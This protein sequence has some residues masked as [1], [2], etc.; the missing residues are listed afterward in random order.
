M[1]MM[2]GEFTGKPFLPMSFVSSATE[3]R[4]TAVRP[5]LPVIPYL[6]LPDIFLACLI[7]VR[8]LWQL[9]IIAFALYSYIILSGLSYTTGDGLNDYS[10]G[11]ALSTRLVTACHFLFLTNPLLDFRHESDIVPAT[12]LSFP[13]RTFWAACA[14]HNIR[15]IGWNFQVG[16]R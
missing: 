12:D 14:S 16:V 4:G 6:I 5:T 1:I 8:P 11:S 10:I 9:R 15:G 3:V 13:R 2:V 7:A